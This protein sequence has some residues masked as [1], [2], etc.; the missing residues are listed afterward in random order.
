MNKSLKTLQSYLL[1]RYGRRLKSRKKLLA[2]QQEQVQRLLPHILALPFYRQRYGGLDPQSWQV[3]PE[4]NREVIVQNFA[5]TNSIGLDYQTA[6]AHCKASAAGS[7]RL[8]TGHSPALGTAT[9]GLSSGTS[10][11]GPRGVFIASE[12]EQ[13]KWAGAILAKCLDR[14]LWARQR[15]AFFLRSNNSLYQSTKQLGIELE[16]FGLEQ[17][18]LEQVG[19]LN[20]LNPDILVAPPSVLRVL[21]SAYKTGSLQVK[22]TK[23]YSCAEVLTDLDK[24][25]IESAFKLRIG[26]IYQATEGFLGI[27]CNA[28]TLHLNEDLLAVQKEQ[29]LQNDTYIVDNGHDLR[30][31]PV[32]TDFNRHTQPILRYR[33]D[34]ILVERKDPCRCGSPFTALDRIEGRLE[35]SFQIPCRQKSQS[36]YETRDPNLSGSNYETRGPNRIPTFIIRQECA[37][38]S[39]GQLSAAIPLDLRIEEYALIQKGE[40]QIVLELR[41][42]PNDPKLVAEMVH[43]ISASLQLLFH[44]KNCVPV[45]ISWQEH[46]PRNEFTTKLRRIRRELHPGSCELNHYISSMEETLLSFGRR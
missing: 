41:C 23:I 35:D 29:L 12:T 24:L 21:S 17:N 46:Q 13:A 37:R 18:P 16:Y 27:T 44:S 14:P 25:H 19:K 28:G 30:F 10:A 31:I 2:W 34:D 5:T 33:V 43:K 11:I 42:N 38:F 45:Q 40:R 20:E 36:N 7:P 9:I 15:I 22:P 6:L 26:Q 4:T 39:P 1:A 3:W 32:V 8:T